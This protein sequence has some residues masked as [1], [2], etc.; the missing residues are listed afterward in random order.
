MDKI[1]NILPPS[2]RVRAAEVADAQPARPG[3]PNFG[4][5]D[6][7]N[8]LGDRVTLSKLAQELREKGGEDQAAPEA[9]V[10][11]TYG[12][13]PENT[14]KQVIAKMS[15]S[16]FSPKA[17]V[18]ES[19]MTSSQQLLSSVEDGEEMGKLPSRMS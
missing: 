3:A 10:A 14:K 18:R 2:A 5:P 11:K 1:S 6:G 8:S 12:N 15:E 16:F 19:D 7:R 13:T 17:E 4:R 9:A